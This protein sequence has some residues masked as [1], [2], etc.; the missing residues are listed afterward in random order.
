MSN[1]AVPGREDGS[2]RFLYGQASVVLKIK[3]KTKCVAQ[4]QNLAVPTLVGDPQVGCCTGRSYDENVRIVRQTAHDINHSR[5]ADGGI[6]LMLDNAKAFDRLQHTFMLDVLQASNL[7]PD[8]LSAV[9]TL[10]T[11][12]PRPA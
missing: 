8:V 12:G 10:C 2:L 4:K 11:T 5:P 3:L 7:P 6:M 9:R 1:E